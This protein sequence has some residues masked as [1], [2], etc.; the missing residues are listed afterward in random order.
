M[1]EQRHIDVILSK[2]KK[3]RIID[4]GHYKATRCEEKCLLIGMKKSFRVKDTENGWFKEFTIS[5]T[6]AK[7]QKILTFILRNSGFKYDEKEAVRSGF[8][9]LRRNEKEE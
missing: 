2:T 8:R 1:E 3:I 6:R 7:I 5:I 4:F 9:N